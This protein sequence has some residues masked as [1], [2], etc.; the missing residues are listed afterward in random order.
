MVAVRSCSL[1]TFTLCAGD[2][3]G[4]GSGPKLHFPHSGGGLILYLK[5][6]TLDLF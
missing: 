1:T 3:G 5:N 2:I 4:C 6:V